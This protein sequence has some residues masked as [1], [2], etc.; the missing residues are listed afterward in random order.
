ME[1]TKQLTQKIY[2]LKGKGKQYETMY[3]LHEPDRR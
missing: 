1:K 2:K 3:G